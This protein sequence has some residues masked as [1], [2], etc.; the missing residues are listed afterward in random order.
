MAEGLI[1]EFEGAGL[2]MYH[3]VS[4]R[5]GI[6]PNATANWP[7]GLLFHAGGAKPGGFVVF[8]VWSSRDAQ[9]AFMDERLGAA[10]QDA[11]V[12]EPPARAEWLELGGYAS[13]G[14]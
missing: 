11:G 13:A 3:A 9:Q 10:L 7:D 4:E 5:L 6:E 1:L 8:E 2:E 14:G 12:T